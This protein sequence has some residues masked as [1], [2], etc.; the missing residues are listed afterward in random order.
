MRVLIFCPEW[1]ILYDK[2][3]EIYEKLKSMDINDGIKVELLDVPE[4][5]HLNIVK[6]ENGLITLPQVLVLGDNKTV[7]LSI[8]RLTIAKEDVEK[9]V[10]TIASCRSR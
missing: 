5:A 9:L 6:S 4:L 10:Q 7:V 3:R 2:C 1:E 8:D